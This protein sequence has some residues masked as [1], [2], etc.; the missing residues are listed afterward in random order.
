MHNSV[1][2]YAEQSDQP[3]NREICAA[4]THP[5]KIEPPPGR[6]VTYVKHS[7]HT[8]CQPSNL[9]LRVHLFPRDFDDVYF[10]TITDWKDA[11]R[12]PGNHLEARFPNIHIPLFVVAE[13]GF[14]TD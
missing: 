1:H 6:R 8:T 3:I 9:M 14:G 7:L 4:W 12:F 10:P 13:S 2:L 5:A 11:L